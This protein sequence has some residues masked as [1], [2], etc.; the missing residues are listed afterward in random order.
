[1]PA[2]FGMCSKIPEILEN[3]DIFKSREALQCQTIVLQKSRSVF[4]LDP[5]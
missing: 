2:K 1:M 5:I 3:I 4:L